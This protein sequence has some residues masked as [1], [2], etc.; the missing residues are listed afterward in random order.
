M[1]KMSVN[2]FP[3]SDI[4]WLN[5]VDFISQHLQ[6]SD[7]ILAPEEFT[8]KFNNVLL[9]YQVQSISKI[10]WLIIHKGMLEEINTNILVNELNNLTPVFANEVF[11]VFSRTS[12]ISDLK[13]NIHVKSLDILIDKIRGEFNKKESIYLN[14]SKPQFSKIK[15]RPLT[16]LG[17]AEE[18]N[19]RPESNF[20]KAM[21]PD[22]IYRHQLRKWWEWEYIAECAEILDCLN[23]NSIAAGLGVGQEPL[24]FYFSNFCQTVLATDIYSS[25]T[26]WSEA[27]VETIESIYQSSPISFD[28]SKLKIENSDMRQISVKDKSVDFVWSTSSIEHLPTLFDVFQVYLE[29]ARILKPGGYAILTTEF[30]LTEPP[31]LLP[32]VNGMDESLFK[33]FFSAFS[34][35]FELVGKEDISYNWFEPANN[36]HV[37]RYLPPGWVDY[38]KDSS[39]KNFKFGQMANA[40]GISA[41]CPIAFVLKRLPSEKYPSWD[42][43]HLPDAVQDYTQALIHLNKGKPKKTINLLRPYIR[44]TAKNISMQLYAHIFRFYI[45]AFSITD[46]S[47]Q[48][49]NNEIEQFLDTVP[50]YICKDA[51]CFD[52]IGYLLQ[53][54][55]N[56]SKAAEVTKMAMLSQ[57]TLHDHAIKLSLRYLKCSENDNNFDEKINIVTDQLIDLAVSGWSPET[58]VTF[59]S[60]SASQE[61]VSDQILEQVIN[62]FHQKKQEK[63]EESFFPN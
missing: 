5:V 41:I 54:S 26:S 59:L 35:I 23:K 36:I 3:E 15:E 19:L 4:H 16:C 56:L 24:S 11:V 42:N 37:R 14:Y 17:D 33:S 63:K 61:G 46:S 57:S 7:S 13:N 50:S 9:Y 27:R 44:S 58:L 49:I 52:L 53:K 6:E 43:I 48:I 29:I 55:G 38:M 1:I 31:Y 60:N 40:V 51:D 20:S 2:K 30:C 47:N 18:I 8:V 21:P 39:F 12:N 10:S 22:Y 62:L 32:G 34:D 25:E 28:R 45:E